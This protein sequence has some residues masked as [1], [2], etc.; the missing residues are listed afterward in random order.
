IIFKSSLT[1]DFEA[2]YFCV[3]TVRGSQ[4]CGL[5]IKT[6]S[7]LLNDHFASFT[8]LK[9]ECLPIN[10]ALSSDFQQEKTT[11]LYFYVIIEFIYEFHYF[12]V[13]F[14]QYLFYLIN[15]IISF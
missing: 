11:H 3:K 4:R 9:T 14:L 12:M 10:I 6:L 8:H 5:L 2:A 13:R 15:I 7:L 1:E